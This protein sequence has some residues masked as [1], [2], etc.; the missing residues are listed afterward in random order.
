LQVTLAAE[1]TEYV[2]LM[3]G[4]ELVM[5]NP[6]SSDLPVSHIFTNSMFLDLRDELANQVLQHSKTLTLLY[7]ITSNPTL[8]RNDHAVTAYVTSP[9]LHHHPFT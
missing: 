5:S 6:S 3:H 2:S 1:N 4:V 7:F 8:S 9:H